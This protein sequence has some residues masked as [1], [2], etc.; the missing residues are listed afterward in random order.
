MKNRKHYV[1]K[2]NLLALGVM[3]SLSLFQKVKKELKE[4]IILLQKLKKKLKKLLIDI[5][6]HITSQTTQMMRLKNFIIV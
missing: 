5:T 1:V 2:E 4:N 3:I 6:Q